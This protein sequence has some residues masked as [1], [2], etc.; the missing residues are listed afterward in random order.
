MPGKGSDMF[1]G[2][3]VPNRLLAWERLQRGWSYEEMADR[4]RAEIERCGERDTGL[5]ANT[6]RRWETGERSPTPRFR[7]H[8]VEIFGKSASE[9]GL[10]LPEE[11]AVRPVSEVAKELRRLLSLMADE[12]R[13][14]GLDRATLL[15]GFLGAGALPVVAGVLG[16]DSESGASLART[17]L[18]QHVTDAG[19]ADAYS[20]LVRGQRDLYWTSPAGELF[21]SAYANAQLGVRLM[22]G[23]AAGGVRDRIGSVLAECGM[24]A[25]RLAFFDLQDPAIAQRC[26]DTALAATREA[27]DHALA[28]GV[29]GHMAFIPGFAKDA[30]RAL[31]L[32]A[33]AHQHCWYGVDPLVR[34]WLHCV[35]AEV[36]GRSPD[37]AGY[38]R[39]VAL[40]ED[41]LNG[42]GEALPEW[43]DFYDPSRLS[44]FAGYC[45]LAAD[46][47]ETAVG[48]L[49][50]ALDQLAASGGKQRSVLL[51]DLATARINDLEQA[52]ALLAE[53]ID[54]LEHDWY[55]TGYQ[56][57]SGVAERLPDGAPKAEIQERKKSLASTARW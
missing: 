47:R 39:H 35:A 12:M 7:K 25:G 36:I 1:G 28:A 20:Q 17:G 49:Q 51:A 6:V 30:S 40:A 33:A 23:A 32:V 15:R 45:A 27:G 44:G 10:L 43:F 14:S 13:A 22:R 31:E 54:V 5:T 2:A 48:C 50:T 57:V 3:R 52:A 34:S 41:S 46:D 56:R 38:R 9:L 21:E 16:L 55:A 26:Y 8:L 11:L 37:P 19:T 53:A 29:L 4:I 24:L 42:S 18:Q